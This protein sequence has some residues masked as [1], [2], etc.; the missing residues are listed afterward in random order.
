ML[1]ESQNNLN[2][3]IIS[4]RIFLLYQFYQSTINFIHYDF[5]NVIDHFNLNF[6]AYR[7]LLLRSFLPHYIFQLSWRATQAFHLSS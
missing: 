2:K 4:I 7:F 6:K 1:L 3:D 5:M